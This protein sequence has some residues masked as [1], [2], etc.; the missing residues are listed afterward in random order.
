MILPL[1]KIVF[2]CWVE[3]VLAYHV[4]KLDTTALT[5]RDRF[6]LVFPWKWVELNVNQKVENQLEDLPCPFWAHHSLVPAPEACFLACLLEKEW[7]TIAPLQDQ[8][9][10]HAWGHNHHQ[11]C[12]LPRDFAMSL[13]TRSDWHFPNT[14]WSLLGSVLKVKFVGLSNFNYS[15]GSYKRYSTKYF[16]KI[17][18]GGGNDHLFGYF[19]NARKFLNT[20]SQFLTYLILL[21][22]ISFLGWAQ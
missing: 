6:K 13:H 22:N 3:M 14:F 12:T 1:N 16:L 8:C 18:M 19:S 4:K 21:A 17:N 11:Y 5:N 7:N 15:L 9:L 20:T 10:I 2:N